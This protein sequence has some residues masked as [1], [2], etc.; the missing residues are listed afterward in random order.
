MKDFEIVQKL[1][2]FQEY[3]YTI[4]IQKI[5]SILSTILIPKISTLV[6]VE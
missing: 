4:F 1:S 6:T 5:F 3:N 2:A